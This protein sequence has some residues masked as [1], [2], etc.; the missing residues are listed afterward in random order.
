MKKMIAMLL[1]VVMILSLCAC[2]GKEYDEALLGVYT[3]YEIEAMGYAMSPDEVWGDTCTIELKQGGKGTMH[4]DGADASVK[5]DI[6]GESIEVKVEG[7]TTTGSLVDGIIEIE[8]MGLTMRLAQEGV[9]PPTSSGETDSEVEAVEPETDTAETDTA[10]NAAAAEPVTGTLGD[11]TYTILAAEHFT[12][13][14]GNPAIRIYFDFTNNGTTIESL[15]DVTYLYAY[16]SGYELVDTYAN[17]DDDV[18]EYGNN[19]VSIAPGVTIRCIGEFSYQPEG[20]VV[21]FKI[22]DYTSDDVLTME[23]D[24]AALSGRPAEQEVELIPN[25]TNTE[26]LPTEGVLEDVYGIKLLNYEVVPG[27]STDKVVRVFIEFTNNSDEAA[28]YFLSASEL[29]L[30]DGMEMEAGLA[31]ESAEEEANTSVEIEPGQSITVAT[32][33]ELTSDSPVE[34]FITDFWAEANIGMM[35]P[36]V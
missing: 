25:P 11:H 27:Y 4:I 9:T 5:Y 1:A 7:E 2:G 21:E 24:P 28:S 8:L 14:D 6:V 35:I 12:D 36:V 33:Y 17:S 16:Q 19:Y 10:E 20:G 18:P 26:G 23:F 30:Q 13:Q 15:W 31:D 22:E 34:F 3:C 32:C 29:A